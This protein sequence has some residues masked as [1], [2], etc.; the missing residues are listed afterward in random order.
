MNC[1]KCNY[2]LKQDDINIDIAAHDS[3]LQGT[4]ITCPECDHKINSFVS[5]RDFVDL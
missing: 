1:R 2:E 4:I 5:E 3:A